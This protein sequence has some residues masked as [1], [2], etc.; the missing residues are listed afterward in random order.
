MKPY[1]QLI[2]LKKFFRQNIVRLVIY[3]GF[4][5]VLYW[6]VTRIIE[7]KQEKDM[8]VQPKQKR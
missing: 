2:P 8:E 6:S 7:I 1:D 4:A 5:L 3:G